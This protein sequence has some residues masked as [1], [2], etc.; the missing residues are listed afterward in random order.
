MENTPSENPKISVIVPTRNSERFLETCLKSIRAQDYPNIEL[1]VV[2]NFS[3]DGTEA[4]A[5]KWADAVYQIGPERSAQIN[6]GASK[7]HGEY[8]F[9]VDSDFFVPPR[10]VSE[11][12]E[13]IDHGF[14][15]VVVNNVPDTSA[16][17]LS[18]IRMFEIQMYLESLE[19]TCARFFKREVFEKVGGYNVDV[20]AGEDYDLQARLVAIGTKFAIASETMIHLDEP[21]SFFVLMRKYFM[22][23]R[24]FHNYVNHNRD[25]YRQK[26]DFLRPEYVKNWRKF[27]GDPALATCFILYHF[28]KFFSGALGYLSEKVENKVRFHR[29]L[30]VD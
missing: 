22:Y 25:G 24:D 29:G 1:I 15:A 17:F 6:Y 20:T 11:C 2:D 8:V 19:H 4:I 12:I 27:V 18:R 7:C 16:G 30:S 3:T 14:E 9:R 23:G 10:V 26:L 5:V 28:A 21:T 13:Y